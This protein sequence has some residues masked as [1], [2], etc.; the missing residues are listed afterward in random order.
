MSEREERRLAGLVPSSSAAD[1]ETLGAETSGPEAKEAPPKRTSS[2]TR[3]RRAVKRWA[4]LL[5]LLGVLATAK[6]GFAPEL[7]RNALDG[8]FYYQI[9]RS[10][11]EG[12]GL[13][14]RVSLYHQ[15]LPEFPHPTNAPPLWPLLLGSVGAL[16]GLEA[17]TRWLPPLL[18]LVSLMLLYALAQAMVP[19]LRGS[20]GR[21]RWDGALGTGLPVVAV[22]HAAVLIFSLDHRFYQFTSLPYTEGLAFAML[23][24]SL[25]AVHR[26]RYGHLGWAALAGG[27][28]G[29]AFLSRGQMLPL[30]LAVVIALGV[31]VLRRG[32]LQDGFRGG[33]GRRLVAAGVAALGSAA[34]VGPWI[35]WLYSW[36]DPFQPRG[37]IGVG[38]YK[39]TP[40]I[41]S[42]RS[43]VPVEG[44]SQWLES[45]GDG[46]VTAFSLTSPNSY[47]DSF[48]FV[49]YLVPAVLLSLLASQLRGPR[50][51][52]GRIRKR[53]AHRQ[54]G[55]A[56]LRWIRWWRHPNRVVILAS[57][58]A[59]LGMLAP[60]HNAQFRFFKEWL[61]GFRHGLPFVLLLIPALIYCLRPRATRRLKALAA[62]LMLAS[63]VIGWERVQRFPSIDFG[64]GLLGPE[65]ELVAWLDEQEPTPSVITTN[66]Q[67]LSAFSRAGFHWMDCD[68][69]AERTLALLERAGANMVLLYPQ[70]QNCAFLQGLTSDLELVK[71]FSRREEDGRVYQVGVLAPPSKV[72]PSSI[73]LKD[74]GGG[75]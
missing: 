3:R 55:F 73:L 11:A 14:T 31:G 59:G 43:Q 1:S 52:R 39:G 16:V 12:E 50:P 18:Y 38:S 44:W 69:S 23:F 48:G 13:V 58:L 72:N 26:A 2:P 64:S 5:V 36:M 35:F 9:A 28:A 6:S 27:F 30:T 70:E 49:A 74:S 66:A 10:V 57:V 47:I 46:L 42:F 34:V 37:V 54:A 24:A 56:P 25:L 17:A 68:E 15:G 8:S 40:G 45:R 32:V 4:L 51:W 33:G 61:F 21:S 60:L 20:S 41:G 29:L 75:R 67:P 62:V 53:A 7:G 22:G 71:V 19:G 65:E 63:V